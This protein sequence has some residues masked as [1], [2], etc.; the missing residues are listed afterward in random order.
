MADVSPG[1]HTSSFRRFR[2]EAVSEDRGAELDRAYGTAGGIDSALETFRYVGAGD[3]DV[4]MR[5]AEVE[6][7]RAGRMAPRADHIVFWIG[8]GTATIED[9]RT[10]TVTV[11]TPGHPVVLSASVP[12]GFRA[13]TRKV[14]LLHLS[15]RVLR[16]TLAARGRLVRGPLLF[17]QQPDIRTALGPLRA[18]LR[19]RASHIADEHLDGA[20]RR[21]LDAE[22]AAAVLDAFPL[23]EPPAGPPSSPAARAADWIRENAGVPVTL[24]DI[25][26]AA[27]LSERGV[28]GA[29]RR[30][31]GESPMERL[32][33]E[34]LDGARRDLEVEG[35]DVLVSEVARRWQF[36]HLGRFAASYAER[37]GEAPSETLRRARTGRS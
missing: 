11:V 10:G 27:G 3:A 20:G 5:G 37:F 15:D 31:F 36:A 26:A 12:Y 7:T 13:D 22:V 1:E 35:P 34:R 19:A 30:T 25:A 18:I 32:R 6:G 24:Q 29:F 16:A 4:S 2:I 14:T 21:A 33:A 17:D 23:V 8:D 28:Q 9:D